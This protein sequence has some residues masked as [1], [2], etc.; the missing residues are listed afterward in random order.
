MDLFDRL[1]RGICPVIEVPFR[2][3]GALDRRGFDS[4]IEHVLGTGV[5]AVLWPAF[6]SEF[7]KLS[8]AER[9]SLRS[10]LLEHTRHRQDVVAIVSIAQHAS[11]LAVEEAT[12][13]VDEGADA[14]NILPP[15]FL[16][17]SRPAVV[18]HLRA[19]LTAIDPVPAIIQHAPNLAASR[20]EPGDMSALASEHPNLR[21][22]KVESVP[23]GA[24]IEALRHCQPALPAMVGYAGVMMIDALRRGAVGVQPGCSAIEI[25]QAIW[26]LWERGDFEEA[27]A[28]HRRLLPYIA[29][30]MQEVELI[31]Q[32]EKTITM[33]RGIIGDDHCRSPGRVLDTE[34]RLAITRF[35]S[36]FAD[37][38]AIR[39][40]HK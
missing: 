9:A 40:G 8:D 25:Y 5:T 35:L 37:L 21:M 14:V 6:A 39:Q 28:L 2:S 16:G 17:P 18:D 11:R 33:Q 7:H 4:V 32:V 3:D 36:E 24:F 12:T 27:E 1:V 19:V 34:E 31:I 23:P 10:Q 13:A 26:Q 20:L 22:V 29:Y 15:H 30:W 38:L